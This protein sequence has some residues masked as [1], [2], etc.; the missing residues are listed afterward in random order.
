M[1]FMAIALATLVCMVAG[2]DAD[3]RSRHRTA[4]DAPKR[5]PAQTTPSEPAP[6]GNA[7]DELDR[8]LQ[9][10]LKNICRGC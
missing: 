9:T 2:D 8:R 1:R 4:S 7:V 5:A 3:A 6:P 10:K